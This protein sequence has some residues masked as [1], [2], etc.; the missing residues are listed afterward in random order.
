MRSKKINK[1][2]KMYLVKMNR[3]SSVVHISSTCQNNALI[4]RNLFHLS[5]FW[6]GDVEQRLWDIFFPESV[7]F[8]EMLVQYARNKYAF[9]QCLHYYVDIILT[10]YKYT[11]I[12]L[13]YIFVLHI[14]YKSFLKS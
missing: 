6:M 9:L 7:I 14:K 2:C 11:I 12:S 4:S 8:A 3:S 1:N 13:I 10:K 5:D